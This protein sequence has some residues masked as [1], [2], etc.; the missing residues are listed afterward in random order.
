MY[1]GGVS[2]W[3]VAIVGSGPTGI[4]AAYELVT[5]SD[6]LKIAIL[7]RGRDLEKRMCP[8][9]LGGGCRKCKPCHMVSGYGG[10]GAFSDGK[11]NL[12][13]DVG[14]RLL[15]Y[16]GRKKLAELIRYVD[17]IYVRFG[18]PE[19]LYGTD[20]DK[21]ERLKREALRENL[22]LLTFPV[23]HMGEKSKEVLANLKKYLEE[24][25]VEFYF[26]TDVSDIIVEGREV[27]GVISS[28]G[29]KF[30]S[31]YVVLAP[32]RSG[33]SWLRKAAKRLGIEVYNDTVD[34]GI[35]VEVPAEIMEPYTSILYEPKFI[36]YTRSFDDKV[37]T[38]CVC[39]YGEVITEVHNGI[40][41]VNGQ[42]RADNTTENTNFAVLVSTRFTEPFRDPISY[43]LDIAK[44]ANNIAGN[45]P[46]IQRL[47]DLLRGRRSTH[48]RIERSIVTRTLEDVTPGDLS[49]VLPYR[50]LRNIIEMLEQLNKVIP[51]VYSDHTLLYGV[52]IKLYSS[53]LKLKSTLETEVRNLYAGGDGAGVSRGLVQASVSG[54][55]IARSILRREG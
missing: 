41:T 42:S 17:S 38:F 47:G 5:R 43:A 49:Y 52:E 46:I 54:V 27:K 55:I 7:E 1:H 2:L 44:L 53:S 28:E 15:E 23:R 29:E 34:I 51:G 3:D 8:M 4:F 24:N 12:S 40:V 35:R 13:P 14:G 48:E 39:P 9:A 30:S 16:V 6:K 10:A 36:Y 25:G 50:Y 21:I 31:K 37:R 26:E 32:G 20:V 19:E 18:A 22:R 33:A 45:K 11:L